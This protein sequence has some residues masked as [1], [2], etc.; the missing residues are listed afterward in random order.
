M[1]VCSISYF[2]IHSL[3]FIIL[4]KQEHILSELYQYI[5]Y[6]PDD[7]DTNQVRKALKY[8]EALNKMFERGYLSHEKDTFMKCEVMRLIEEGFKFFTDWITTILNEGIY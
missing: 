8:L 7:A 4:L 5:F 6:K 1:Q 2:F 3:F